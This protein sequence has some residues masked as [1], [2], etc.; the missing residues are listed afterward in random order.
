MILRFCFRFVL[1]MGICASLA[2][3]A[4]ARD[5]QADLTDIQLACG[6]P[7]DDGDTFG[8]Q[9]Y[10]YAVISI[11][12]ATEDGSE[13][14]KRYLV[15]GRFAEMESSPYM[16]CV[17]GRRLQ[18]ISGAAP[19]RQ[20]ELPAPHPP[21]PPPPP[22]PRPITYQTNNAS[23]MSS[24][25][26]V[27]EPRD[28]KANGVV[29]PKGQLSALRNVCSFQLTVYY[30]VEGISCGWGQGSGGVL[31]PGTSFVVRARGRDLRY[32]ACTSKTANDP[33]QPFGG[34]R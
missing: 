27:I 15:D 6:N 33:A 7:P 4:K 19:D 24:C 29:A 32:L 18:Q 17:F 25:I 3:T 21:P 20:P 22:P 8:G 5:R 9:P 23:N 16:A 31:P 11:L 12:D 28:F 1:G 13:G 2:G 14:Q 10:R 30:C 26:R 34:C